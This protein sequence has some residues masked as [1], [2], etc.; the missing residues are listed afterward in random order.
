MCIR[1]TQF[2]G[3]QLFLVL[4]FIVLNVLSHSTCLSGLSYFQS[5]GHFN[6]SVSF[7]KGRRG[8]IHEQ[9]REI[10]GELLCTLQRKLY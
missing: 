9:W 4:C 1:Q 5:F 10:P 8:N 3:F 2:I 7:L 6:G